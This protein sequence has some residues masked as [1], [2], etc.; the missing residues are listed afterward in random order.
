MFYH[1]ISFLEFESTQIST[2]SQI[3][4]FWFYF[5]ENLILIQIGIGILGMR[6]S[7]AIPI[8][9]KKLQNDIFL[10]IEKKFQTVY[11]VIVIEILLIW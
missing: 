4:N 6:I 3:F 5:V 7:Q 9:P 8:L 1:F 2:P 10:K 11:N